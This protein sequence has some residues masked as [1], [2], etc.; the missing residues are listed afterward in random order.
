MQKKLV[1]SVQPYESS[2]AHG[3]SS[4]PARMFQW[5]AAATS[6]QNVLKTFEMAIRH[7][8]RNYFFSVAGFI[9]HHVQKYFS[10]PLFFGG[11]AIAPS[12]PPPYGLD[13]ATTRLLRIAL[14]GRISVTGKYTCT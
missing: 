14:P 6:G 5:D 11:G 1:H 10:G 3:K 8:R 12:P 2:D 9:F 4:K 7:S 13:A